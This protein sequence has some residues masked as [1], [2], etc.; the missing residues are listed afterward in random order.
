MKNNMIKFKVTKC[1]SFD[2]WLITEEESKAIKN[3]KY[4]CFIYLDKNNKVLGYYFAYVRGRSDDYEGVMRV[5]TLK[6]RSWRMEVSS[7]AIKWYNAGGDIEP[8]ATTCIIKDFDSFL[9]E[10]SESEVNLF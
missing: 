10:V 6:S 2:T 7:G 4:P 1:P 5:N 8:K 3:M 9:E